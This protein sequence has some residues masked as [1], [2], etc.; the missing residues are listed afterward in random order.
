MSDL[1]LLADAKH[2]LRV[3]H[4]RDD[5]YI[6]L[7]IKAALKHI[8][9]FID[10]PFDDI[11]EEDGSFPADLVI[12]TYLILNDMYINRANQTEVN[13]YVNNATQNYMLPYRKM[14]V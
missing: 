7:L 6:E 1:I 2:Q 12:A 11:L 13:L 5:N 14:G 8:R 10:Q 4:D 3:V 9:N